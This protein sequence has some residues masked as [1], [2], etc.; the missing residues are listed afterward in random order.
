MLRILAILRLSTARG[1]MDQLLGSYFLF[2]NESNDC[3]NQDINLDGLAQMRLKPGTKRTFRVFFP[4]V[5]SQ[6]QSRDI[7]KLLRAQ[8]SYSSYQAVPVFDRHGDVTDEH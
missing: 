3:P 2:R 8:A 5:C 4:S 6:G 7:S 1:S